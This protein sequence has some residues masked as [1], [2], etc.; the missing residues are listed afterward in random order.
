MEELSLFLLIG[1]V[2][3]I[4]GRFLFGAVEFMVTQLKGT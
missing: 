3:G 2:L 1:A 4:I